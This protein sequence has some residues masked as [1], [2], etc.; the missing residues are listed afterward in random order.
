[1]GLFIVDPGDL[2][3][4][5]LDVGEGVEGDER[6]FVLDAV[7]LESEAAS[8]KEDIRLSGG[9]EIGDAVAD[10]N[11]QRDG[12]VVGLESGGFPVLVDGLSLVVPEICIVSPHGFPFAAV[13]GDLGIVGHDLDVLAHVFA[14][15]VVEHLSENGLQPSRD[16]VEGDAIIDTEFVELLEIRVDLQ[17]GL[18]H[19]EPIVEGHIQGSV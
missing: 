2:D 10:K 14:D 6:E 13:L 3:D 19:L 1:M 5:A 11:D 8:R 12:A 18:H 15:E 9:G 16:D 4:L 7:F 17:C